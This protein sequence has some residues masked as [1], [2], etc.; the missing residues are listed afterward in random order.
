M[1]GIF[2]GVIEGDE[3]RGG[4]EVCDERGGDIGV[5]VVMAAVGR[6]SSD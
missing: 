5:K 1:N 4:G 3:L 2:D 6:L